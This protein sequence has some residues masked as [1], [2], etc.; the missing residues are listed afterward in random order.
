MFDAML[1]RAEGLYTWR[2]HA[3][4]ALH[5]FFKREVIFDKSTLAA[6]VS[7]TLFEQYLGFFVGIQALLILSQCILQGV[8]ALLYELTFAAAQLCS[9][10][11]FLHALLQSKRGLS[12]F[13]TCLLLAACEPGPHGVNS[14]QNVGAVREAQIVV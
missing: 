10:Q 9:I 3:F 2:L 4:A 12:H 14:Y 11:L 6:G 7:N 1:D 13:Y 5:Q 8:F